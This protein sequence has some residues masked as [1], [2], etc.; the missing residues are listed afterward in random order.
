MKFYA[1][2]MQYDSGRDALGYARDQRRAHI[3][4]L[5]VLIEL[6]PVRVLDGEREA[7]EI[8]RDLHLFGRMRETCPECP[9]EHLQLVLRQ[10]H[11]KIAHLYC[12]RCK[13]C[14]DACYPNGVSAL[15]VH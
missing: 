9:G 3:E 8:D 11:V 13:R 10:K 5:F 15:A 6:D 4:T 12:Q 7:Y 1:G 2:N 14:F